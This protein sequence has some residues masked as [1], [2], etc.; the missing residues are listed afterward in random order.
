M[1]RAKRI[2]ARRIQLFTG[3]TA[4]IYALALDSAKELI[5]TGGGDGMLIEWDWRQ[6]GKGRLV[7]KVNEPIYSLGFESK[8]EFLWIGTASGKVHVIDLKAKLELKVF[9]SHQN[10]VYDLKVFG[11]K[12]LSAGGDGVLSIYDLVSQK[13]ERQIRLS[14]KSLRCI[15]INST[16]NCIAIGSS[17]HGIYLLRDNLDLVNKKLI[18][19]SNSVFSVSFSPDGQYLLSGGRDA[20]MHIYE[21]GDSFKV[22]KSIA[23]HNLHVHSISVQKEVPYFLSSSMDKSI[24]I[25]AWQDF[26][27][28][29]VMDKMRHNAHA[30]SINKVVWINASVFASIS[31]DKTVMIWELES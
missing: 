22:L 16:M 21:V 7:A 10:G 20:M 25:W 1:E 13:L 6:E 30:N 27:L 12:L 9:E 31:D 24:K 26:E 11:Q 19:H 17:D 2:N 5:Y 14:N 8:Q 4:A 15:A 18:Q 3:H 23:A 29:R 28:L